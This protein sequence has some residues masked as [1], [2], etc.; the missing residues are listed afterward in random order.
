MH[1]PE[2]RGVPEQPDGPPDPVRVGGLAPEVAYVCVGADA[3]PPETWDVPMLS[4]LAGV[5]G[6][7][8]P[9]NLSHLRRGIALAR[10]PGGWVA[11]ERHAVVWLRRGRA[12]VSLDLLR[13]HDSLYALRDEAGGVWELGPGVID[14]IGVAWWR[15]G[16]TPD[17][18]PPGSRL[19]A[20]GLAASVTLDAATIRRAFRINFAPATRRVERETWHVRLPSSLDRA[21]P[22]GV[23][24]WISPNPDGRLPPAY[25]SVLDQIG[26]IAIGADNTGNGRPLAERLQLVLDGV[27]ILKRRWL[28]DPAAVYLAGLSGG[29]RC[30]AILQLG[31]PE[32]FS[33]TVAVA[34]LDS[35]H[36]A[37]T[38]NL[39]EIWPGALGKPLANAMRSL[40]DRRIAALLGELDFNRAEAAA[41]VALLAA[42]GI[43]ARLEIVPGL[44][45]ALAPAPVFAENLR[46]VDE[47]CR[48]A[49]QASVERATALLT[50]VRPGPDHRAALVG[51]IRAAPWSEPAWVAA[52]L[53]GYSRQ[54]FLSGSP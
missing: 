50:A 39:A 29:G 49:S 10:D 14:S 31:M 1:E 17:A 32:V 23:L 2:P 20:A 18:S 47:P 25:E 44:G 38:G 33:G 6:E 42:D 54:R 9:S 34:G 24:I 28:I 43:P 46:W 26:F 40:R 19:R 53:L 48:E 37:P 41:R 5:I 8:G 21:R 12:A 52:E 36:D 35:Y 15:R 27:E 45:Q 4:Q 13:M 7:L 30:A 11:A 3:A 51:V 22:S 16:W